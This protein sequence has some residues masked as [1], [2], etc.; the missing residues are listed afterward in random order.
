MATGTFPSMLPKET[1]LDEDAKSVAS[2]TEVVHRAPDKEVEFPDGGLRAWLVAVGGFA[3][4]FSTFGFINTW[5][6]F[7]AY[8]QETMLPHVSPSKIA[9]IGSIQYALVFFPGLVTGRMFDLGYFRGPQL[10]AASLFVAGTFLTAECKEY[11]QFLLCQGLAV[12]LASGLLFGTMI[13]VITHW[14]KA[15]RGLAIGVAA[16]GSSIGGTIIPIVARRL[17]PMIGFKWAIRVIG[18]ILLVVVVVAV[19]ATRR[20]LPPVIVA[21]GL[22][23]PKAF[24]YAPY[25]LYV[26]SALLAWLGLYTVLTYL[27]VYA[28]EV[29]IFSKLDPLL[30]LDIQRCLILRSDRL[31][32][33]IRSYRATECADTSNTDNRCGHLCMAICT[34]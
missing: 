10:A 27:Q 16:S 5:G 17:I 18:F 33:F 34:Q 3:I 2:Q 21:G 14:F 9:W 22:F 8:Y 6:V 20:R 31:G 23:N 15:R 25:S 19:L 4:T 11:W 13:P 24:S 12:G 26:W 1:R 30:D 32:L 7:Q 29:N 28:K